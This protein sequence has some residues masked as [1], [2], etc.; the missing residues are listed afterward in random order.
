MVPKPVT[1]VHESRAR[2][3]YPMRPEIIRGFLPPG[4]S[5]AYML[6]RAGRPIYVG[7]SDTCLR[8]RLA[9]HPHVA[10]A[11]H[12]MW[13]ICRDPWQAFVLEAAL[14]H[15]LQHVPD[16]L[17]RVHPGKPAP[18]TRGCPFCSAGDVAALRRLLGAH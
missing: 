1:L 12:V 17:N 9:S 3:A 15:R 18:Y 6:L 16:V 10:K 2:H 14:F 11:S 7:R 8:L 13:E 5:G 4:Y